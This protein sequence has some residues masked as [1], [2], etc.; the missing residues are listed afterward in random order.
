MFTRL[1][2][3]RRF[4]ALQETM[5]ERVF[6]YCWSRELVFL[7]GKKEYL[8]IGRR[9]LLRRRGEGLLKGDNGLVVGEV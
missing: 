5:V 9:Q 7:S 8:S 2:K 3:N 4:N 6:V 1:W